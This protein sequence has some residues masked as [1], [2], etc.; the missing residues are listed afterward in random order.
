M[1][2]IFCSDPLYPNRPDTSY[3]DEVQATQAVGLEYDLLNFEELTM[4][5]DAVS[6]LRRV[7]SN[8]TPELA[9]YR[10][11]MLRPPAYEQL[12][13]TLQER[14]VHLINSPSAYQH[15]HFLPESY[16]AIAEHTPDSVWFPLPECLDLER[17]MQELVAFGDKPLILKDYVKSRKHEW[18]EACYISSA[19]D[20]EEVGRVIR[21]FLELQGDAISVGLVFREYVPL[22]SIGT[23]SKSGMPLTKEFRLFFFD[24]QLLHS[25][26]YWT[27]GNY[28]GDK[29]PVEMFQSVAQEVQSR[30]FT[31]DVA[32]GI[33]GTWII[34]ELGDA[35][36]AGLPNQND[37]NHFYQVLRNHT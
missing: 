23:H 20:R 37:S 30:F 4:E 17:V 13:H 26:E 15:C 36:V 9:I 29:P 12:Y 35:Q 8:G 34:I 1:K 2:I 24:A 5:K 33:D 31:M 21:R 3:E 7:Q 28:S 19:S 16:T 27:E 6:A 11:W 25:S 22:Q 10:G 14:G 32:Q 18:A